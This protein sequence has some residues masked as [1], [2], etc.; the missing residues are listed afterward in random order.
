MKNF[1]SV[2]F[3]ATLL[4]ACNSNTTVETTTT[5]S[6]ST[7]KDSAAISIKVDTSNET[8]K[9][10]KEAWDTAKSKVKKAA[11]AVKTGVD[12]MANRMKK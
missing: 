7:I 6:D 10:V 12:T 9:D 4:S 1:F 11:D 2:F 8:V 5:G 3:L